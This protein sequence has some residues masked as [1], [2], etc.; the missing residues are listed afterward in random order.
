MDVYKYPSGNT[1]VDRI[2][3]GLD[4]VNGDGIDAR[5]LFFF[6][7]NQVPVNGTCSVNPSE[8]TALVT[9][10]KLLCTGWVDPEGIG[11]KQYVAAGIMQVLSDCTYQTIQSFRA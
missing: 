8:G 4:T 3:M 10:F 9:N 11:I 1:L 6:H 2:N 7:I 5:N